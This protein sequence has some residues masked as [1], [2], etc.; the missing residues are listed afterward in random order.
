LDQHQ[1]SQA[2]GRPRPHPH[3]VA[4]GVSAQILYSCALN[5]E[6]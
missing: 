6:Q 5:H 1:G 3:E 2:H 4:P